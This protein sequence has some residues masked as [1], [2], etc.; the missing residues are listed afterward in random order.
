VNIDRISGGKIVEHWSFSD[1]LSMWDQL[2][3]AMPASAKS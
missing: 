2:G 1:R 3:V